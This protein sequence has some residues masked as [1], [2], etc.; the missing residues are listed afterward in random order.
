M[1]KRM[2]VPPSPALPASN[3]PTRSDPLRL[4]GYRMEELAWAFDRV[5]DP[6]DWMAPIQAEIRTSI[7]PLV[8]EAILWF[9]RTIPAVEPI[10]GRPSTVRVRALGYRLGPDGQTSTLDELRKTDD[11]ASL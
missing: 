3:D 6:Y 1:T 9:T 8:R 11:M 7:L 2:N 4:T 5:K 10:P